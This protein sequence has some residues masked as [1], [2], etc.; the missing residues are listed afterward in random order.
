M[1]LF[2]LSFVRYIELI[3]TLIKK[4]VNR[5]NFYIVKKYII[6]LQQPNE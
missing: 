2:Y 1:C 5:F 4:N 6:G 3:K